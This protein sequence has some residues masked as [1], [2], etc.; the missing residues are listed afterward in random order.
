MFDGC[1]NSMLEQTLGFENIEWVITLHNCK[2]EHIDRVREKLGNYDNVILDVLNNDCHTAASPR[3]NGLKLATSDYV[4]FLDGDD[5][6]RPDALERLVG[7][8]GETGQRS[9]CSAESMSLNFRICSRY[10]RLCRGIPQER[11]L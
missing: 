6:F 1:V 11:S 9:S 5:K 4:A 2:A 7:Y 10:L 8:F 3:N